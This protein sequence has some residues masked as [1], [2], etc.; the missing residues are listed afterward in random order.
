VIIVCEAGGAYASEVKMLYRALNR[1]DFI[2][3]LPFIADRG[4]DSV[5]IIQKILDIGLIPAIKVK[6]TF[7][8]RTR[9]P[10][11]RLSNQNWSEYGKKRYRIE[12]LFG[13]I[14]NKANSVFRSKRE[15]MAKKLAIA[16]A[17]LWNFCMILTFLFYI[18]FVL[19]ECLISKNF[20]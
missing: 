19:I 14:N 4:Y 20:F 11:R 13:N 2:K 17:I 8:M 9:H 1:V 10:L 3:G 16:W 15:D 18:L 6:E 12:S 7:R 5:N